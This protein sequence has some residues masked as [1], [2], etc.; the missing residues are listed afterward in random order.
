[1]SAPTHDAPTDAFPPARHAAR[2]FIPRT[3]RT[4]A[5]PIIIAWVA[6]I[7]VL[8]VVVPQ[9]EAV[10]QMRAVSMSPDDAPSMIAMK[11]VGQ[12][13]QESESDS[14]AMIVLE[15]QEPLGDAAHKFYDEMVAKLEADTKHVEHVQD[16]WSDPLTASGSQS[17]DGKA[18]YVQV[19]L[20]GNQG[21]S[22]ANESVESVQKIDRRAPAAALG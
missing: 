7:A 4:L 18:A 6:L 19:Y 14:A 20:A 5:I 12:V 10:G 3:I 8:N 2:P 13:F 9:L 21:E 11:R 1:M 16:F 22:L 17:N 15:G